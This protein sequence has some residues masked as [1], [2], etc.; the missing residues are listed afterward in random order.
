MVFT[1]IGLIIRTRWALKL[2]L[3]IAAL[4]LVRLARPVPLLLA[5]VVLLR[6]RATLDTLLTTE[7]GRQAIAHAIEQQQARQGITPVG[8]QPS[9]Q[10]GGTRFSAISATL[11]AVTFLCSRSIYPIVTFVPSLSRPVC[12]RRLLDLRASMTQTPD[13]GPTREVGHGFLP[14]SEIF[15]APGIDVTVAWAHRPLRRFDRPRLTLSARS[16]K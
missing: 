15:L 12:L 11:Y 3:V 16:Y 9:P 10:D 2:A 8:P 7:I 1:G 6:Q 4:K 14:H 5:T 13:P